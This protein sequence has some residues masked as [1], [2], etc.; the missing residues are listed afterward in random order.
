MTGPTH[1]TWPGVTC[2]MQH[3]PLWVLISV[4]RAFHIPLPVS[5]RSDEIYL[6]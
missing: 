3:S 4:L 5:L 2:Y 6:P 1:D